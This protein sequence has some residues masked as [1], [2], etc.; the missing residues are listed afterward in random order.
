MTDEEAL[1]T[2]TMW[3]DVHVRSDVSMSQRDPL[4][5]VRVMSKYYLEKYSD[6]YVLR[7][8]MHW[9][10]AR[11]RAAWSWTAGRIEEA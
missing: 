4:F 8:H 6:G 5:A 1:F 7:L 9:R 2:A 10:A 3:M 11:M